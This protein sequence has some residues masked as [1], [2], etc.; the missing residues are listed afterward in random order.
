[1]RDLLKI[2]DTTLAADTAS[3]DTN[4]NGIPPQYEHLLISFYARTGQAFALTAVEVTFNGDTGANYDEQRIIASGGS[5]SAG[6]AVGQTVIAVHVPGSTATAN[7][8]AAA[9]MLVIGYAQTTTH[10]A[11]CTQTGAAEPTL[12]ITRYYASRWRNTAAINRVRFAGGG[13]SNL[14]AGSRFT[15]YGLVNADYMIRPPQLDYE[16]SR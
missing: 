9:Q 14:I 4:I 12:D 16:F 7:V 11:I 3:V 1:M 13:A 10:K 2:W 5:V 15:I 8:Y 6:T